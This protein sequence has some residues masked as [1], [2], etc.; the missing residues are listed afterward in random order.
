MEPVEGDSD[1]VTEVLEDPVTVVVNCWVPPGP[2]VTVEGA[3]ETAT[4]GA[5]VTLIETALVMEPNEAET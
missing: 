2:S 5:G 3:T 4:K 1:H